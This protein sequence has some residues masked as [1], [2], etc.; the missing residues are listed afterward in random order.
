M[1][2]KENNV[3]NFPS[4]ELSLNRLIL[5]AL[6]EI[7]MNEFLYSEEVFRLRDHRHG[8]L[9]LQGTRLQHVEGRLADEYRL[10]MLDGLHRAYCETATI[11]GALHLVQHWDLRIS[12]NT[13]KRQLWEKK[14]TGI[15]CG[16]FTIFHSIDYE[17]IIVGR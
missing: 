10:S 16:Q 2:K 9:V 3:I 8:E 14:V 15:D 12:C 17:R 5:A 6:P 11:S 4:T 7:K 1:M 13:P